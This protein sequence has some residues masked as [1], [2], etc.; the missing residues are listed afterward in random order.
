MDVT[1]T[2]SRE[3]S[4]LRRALVVYCGLVFVF[5]LLP[6][7]I[8]FPV[9]FSSAQSLQFPPPGY[10]LR[11]YQAYFADDIWIEATVRSLGIAFWTMIGATLLGGM[12]AYS[13]VRGRFPGREVV[14]QLATAPIMAPTIIY[15][16]AVYGLFSWLKLIG[17]WQGIVLG[18]IVHA[19]PLVVLVV[20]A[21]LR[22]VDANLELAAQGLGASQLTAIRRITLPQIMPSIVS[23]AFLSFISSFDELVIAMFLGGSN[24]TLPKRMFDN[25]QLE[26]EPTVAAVSVLQI[27]LVTAVLL[28]VGRVGAGAAP[29]HAQGGEAQRPRAT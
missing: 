1:T 22:T 13:L 24:W 18:H 9:S 15:A 5:L 7:A 14:N 28:V 19:L 17:L 6:L 3:H 27:V 8:V 12:L 11:W 16:V 26:I 4:W 25:I 20:G 2:G 10:S 21:G 23:A 29:I